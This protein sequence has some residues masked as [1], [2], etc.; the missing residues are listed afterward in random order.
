MFQK[1]KFLLQ[2]TSHVTQPLDVGI[3]GPLI[4]QLSSKM[5]EFD[6]EKE[7]VKYRATLVETAMYY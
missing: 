2:H 5:M 4:S 1:V 7:G 3:F 6:E